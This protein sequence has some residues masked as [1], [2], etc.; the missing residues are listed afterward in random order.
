MQRNAPA[1]EAQPH[2]G[3]LS[4]GVRHCGRKSGRKG[5]IIGAWG[6]ILRGRVGIHLALATGQCDID[7]AASVREPLLRAAL[8]SLLLLLLLD[9]RGLRLDLAGTSQTSVN[10][11]H[12]R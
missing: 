5:L 2:G 1:L 8:R 10:F 11:A 9:L 7:E 6:S 3:L 12:L 4:S